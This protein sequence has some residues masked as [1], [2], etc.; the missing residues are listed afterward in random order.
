MANTGMLFIAQ[1][2]ILDLVTIWNADLVDSGAV[3]DAKGQIKSVAPVDFPKNKRTAFDTISEKTNKF[4]LL[5]FWENLRHDNL[6]T[7]FSNLYTVANQRAKFT[8]NKKSGLMI[9]PL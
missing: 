6:L 1:C 2:R 5:V 8:E 7:V 3:A 9:G 4:G